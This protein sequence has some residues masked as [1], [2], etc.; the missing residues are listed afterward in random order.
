MNG[1]PV[2]WVA[3]AKG[4]DVGHQLVAQTKVLFENGLSLF[5]VRPDFILR[6]AAMGAEVWLE[7]AVL[8]PANVELRIVVVVTDV[9]SSVRGIEQ[10][11]CGRVCEAGRYCQPPIS[12][13]Q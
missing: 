5:S 11:G 8:E 2:L 4:V 10:R 13:L 9:C 3:Y 7:G 1:A 12:V 6:T